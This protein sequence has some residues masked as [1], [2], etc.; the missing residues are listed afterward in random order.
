M[1]IAEYLLRNARNWPDR[2][3][4]VSD[5]RR[6]TWGDVADRSLRLAHA[7]RRLGVGA[8]DVIASM[9]EDTHETV[10]VW[11]AAALIGAV[12]TGVNVRYAPAETAHVLADAGTHVLVVEGGAGESGLDRLDPP[13]PGLRHVIGFGRHRQ[14]LD[15]E[16]LLAGVPPLPEPAGV[17]PDACAAISYTTG[18]TGLP[19]G[20]RWSHRAIAATQVNT[21]L[22]AGMQHD[23]VFLHCL[24]AAGVPILLATWNVVN[25]AA[26]VLH[27]RFD[28]G[29]ALAQMAQERVTSVLWVPTMMGDVLAHPGF[30]E[31]DLG[32]LRLVMYGSMP[33]TPTLVR[34]ALDGFGCRLQQ[35]YGS[36]EATA[37]W[38]SI[39]H[40]EDHLAALDGRPELLTS[41]GRSTLQCEMAVLDEAGDP[42]PD[43][44]VGEICVRGETLMLGYHNLPDQTAAVLRG[45]GWLRMGDLG[46]RDPQGY[47]YL[48][49]R[50]HFMIITGGYNVYPMVVENALAEHPA[51]AE[52]AVVGAPDE[53][54][55]EVV[56]AVVVAGAPVTGAELVEFCR[57]R[58]ASFEVPKRIDFA[59]RLPRGATGKVAKRELRERYRQAVLQM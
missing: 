30:A 15:Y 28:A 29:R 24:P 59:D 38:T 40:H 47:F 8:G 11:Y 14:A 5:T 17:N 51:V 46:F 27:R 23:D 52:V 4:Y 42:V 44:T 10:E 26:V 56:C 53:R 13:V 55:G 35:W 57:T 21:W 50:K 32:S 19:K 22:Q 33:A 6:L 20:V 36:T 25:G 12:R 7:L 54:W 1:L 58:V 45:D 9:A 43:G 39:L 3:A 2:L 16:T 37:G 41:C 48:V 34:R 18:S 31:Y 49:D